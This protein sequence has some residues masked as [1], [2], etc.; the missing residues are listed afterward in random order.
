MW[1]YMSF[2]QM[3]WRTYDVLTE[4]QGWLQLKSEYNDNTKKWI[5]IKTKDINLASF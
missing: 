5:T 3:N 1:E 4:G 2:D